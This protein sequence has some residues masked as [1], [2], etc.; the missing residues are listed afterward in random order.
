MPNRALLDLIEHVGEAHQDVELDPSEEL[1]HQLFMRIE[2]QNVLIRE[3]DIL[4]E[5][6]HSESVHVVGPSSYSSLSSFFLLFSPFVK[7]VRIRMLKEWRLKGILNVFLPVRDVPS[8][9][10][11]LELWGK[12]TF[13]ALKNFTVNTLEVML[14]ELRS[15]IRRW[16]K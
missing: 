13:H 3:K 9:P 1:N 11:R 16:W 15:L 2:E 8:F 5:E 14:M 7:K 10:A 4:I 12:K 6:L